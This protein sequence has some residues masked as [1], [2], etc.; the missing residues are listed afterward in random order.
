M[1]IVHCLCVEPLCPAPQD[2]ASQA[3]VEE[4]S[5][6]VEVAKKKF[7]FKLLNESWAYSAKDDGRGKPTLMRFE[8]ARDI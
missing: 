4:M 7:G 5:K 3:I 1:W 8:V 2:I 6:R